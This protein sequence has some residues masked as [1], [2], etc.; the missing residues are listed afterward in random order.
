MS[1]FIKLALTSELG[2]KYKHLEG[3]PVEGFMY[4]KGEWI[5]PASVTFLEIEQAKRKDISEEILKI[6]EQEDGKNALDKGLKGKIVEK[7][8]YEKHKHIFPYKKWKTVR[9]FF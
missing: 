4:V 8:V 6:V 9:L 2:R 5:I 1:D 7:I 3:A